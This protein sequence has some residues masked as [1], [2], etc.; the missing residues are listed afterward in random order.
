MKNK[1]TIFVGDQELDMFGD[2]DI[3]I[4]LSVQNIQDISKVFTDFTQ[5]FSVPAS[6]RNNAIF[7][8]YYRTDIVGGADY[9][10]RAEGYIEI[11]GLV[12]RYGSI[13]LEGVQM[14]QNAPYA[15]DITFY[16]L[17]VNLTDL[18]GEDYLY[19]LDGLSAYNLDYTPNNVYTGLV[20]LGLNS[21]VFPLITAKDVWFYE[22]NNTQ[23]DPNNIYYHNQ[24]QTHGVQYYDL[25]PAIEINKVVAA[26]E[27]KYG[28]TI[29]V[30]G[31]RDYNKLH[32]WCHR[33][34]GYMYKDL[35]TAMPWTKILA[36]TPLVP[37]TPDWWDYTASTFSN[38][39]PGAFVATLYD[40]YISI[41]VGAYT[42]DYNVGIFV[43]DI[44]IAQKTLNGTT[45]TTFEDIV[46]YRNNE[47]YYAIQPSTNESVT[48][49]GAIDI[50]DAATS[51]VRASAYNT[52][53]QN[54][55][56]TI[57][58]P[59]LMPEQKITDF[60]ASLCKMFNLVIIP[61]SSTEFNLL[62]I[63]EWYALGSD[64]D[65][66]QYFDITESQVER[67]Q[68][69]KQIQFQYNETGAITGEQYRLTNDIGYGDLRSEFV[70]DTD[71]ELVV[72]PQFDQMLFTRLT[73]QDGGALTK[74]LAG[75]A[76][77]RELETYLGQ[78]FIFYVNTPVSIYPA[79]LSFIDPTQT[80][81]S[82]HKSVSVT[83]VVYA[84]AANQDF[85]A[86][87]TYSLN[88]GADL[89]PYLL[90]SVN[91]SLYNEY[92]QDYITDLYDPSRRLVRIPAILPLGKILNFDLKN[93]LLWNGQKWV[94]NNVQINLTTGKA[95]FELLNNV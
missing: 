85:N 74:L 51:V 8:H 57:D 50:Q 55:S 46:M 24:N 82:G 67:P 61:T 34:A 76:V 88:Y 29:N 70:F 3:V 26:I 22:S 65:L 42:G 39:V 56:G 93:K 94:V 64:V 7:E 90:Q 78:P 21:I 14:R 9:R 77:T 68:L 27:D 59:S 23:N 38:L 31:I 66:S 33:N 17:L 12:F 43:N 49:A 92:W 89:D 86:A 81:I 63:D 4:N 1:V 20:S 30:S 10:L 35:P 69:Y 18:F 40:F 2:E 87:S 11:N 52:S 37:I 54:I 47:A 13:E 53:T 91:N 75:Y 80:I 62:P 36:P 32:I 95:E 6:P 28:I 73:D 48:F 72:Q 79:I 83:Q 19:D 25:K 41:N 60:L 45:A 71:E 5:G 84:N 16:G 44:L 58:I 15:Y